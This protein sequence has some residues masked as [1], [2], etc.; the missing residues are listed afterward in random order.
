MNFLTVVLSIV[1]MILLSSAW[2]D[3]VKNATGIEC[4][5]LADFQT[6]IQEAQPKYHGAEA[7]A[8]RE[9]L[10]GTLE[11]VVSP[12]VCSSLLESLP[13]SVFDTGDAGYGNSIASP[14]AYAGLTLEDLLRNSPSQEGYE[15]FLQIREKLRAET[16]RSL[17]LCEGSLVVDFTH[18]SQKTVGG[19]HRPHADNCVAHRVTDTTED[20]T[21]Y[22]E[23]DM[24]QVHPYAHRIAASI[25]FLND[26]NSGNYQDGD[27][28]WSSVETGE[29]EILVQPYPGRMTY[30]TSGIENLHGALP[31]KSANNEESTCQNTQG[32]DS[33]PS[34]CEIPRRLAIAM[35]Y[36]TPENPA[37]PIPREATPSGE[38]DDSLP[39]G[40][41][42][43]VDLPMQYV[44]SSIRVLLSFHLMAHQ[45]TPS[46]DSWKLVQTE[47][48]PLGMLFRDHTALLVVR[49]V[50][51][52]IRIER[53]PAGPNVLP[54]LVYQLQESLLVHAILDHLEELV[55]ADPEDGG[56]GD[57]VNNGR[58]LQLQDEYAIR[59][60]R[61]K[62]PAR[63]D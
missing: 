42:A 19:Q 49:I 2:G 33:E 17:G 20:R 12:E 27:F 8:L 45:H 35:W 58:L 24:D 26:P 60:A 63:R 41:V 43:I 3:E 13:P 34:S 30:F 47:E 54:S 6:R 59:E 7:Q 37:E 55:L 10:R 51:N 61:T 31:V 9:S 44:K 46:Q 15:N 18:V 5:S 52:R 1:S 50:S 36:T 28:F 14:K 11:H 57:E 16:E 62:L 23:C 22:Y 21:E 38:E 39:E 48:I 32:N 29:P 25:L 40:A 56:D 53:H 4:R